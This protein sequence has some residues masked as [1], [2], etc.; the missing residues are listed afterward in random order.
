MCDLPIQKNESESMKT[1]FLILLGLILLFSC[2]EK[3]A[4]K[5]FQRIAIAGL[6]IESSTFSTARST[7]QAF[8]VRTG[9]K[10]FSYNPFMVPDSANRKRVLL[11]PTLRG[12]AILGG[13]ADQ[14]TDV[15]F[16]PGL[17]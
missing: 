4:Q 15:S 9:E 6:A 5:D 2:R 12:H 7:A 14:S 1:T 16:G 13:I 11:F 10:I 8:R 17:G 3:E